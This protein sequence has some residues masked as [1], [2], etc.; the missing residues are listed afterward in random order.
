MGFRNFTIKPICNVSWIC[1]SCYIHMHPFIWH[2]ALNL[3]WL[4]PHFI[5]IS[6][7]IRW[8]DLPFSQVSVRV[9][10]VLIYLET[11]LGTFWYGN[12][13]GDYSSEYGTLLNARVGG[14]L[15]RRVAR[16]TWYLN[17]WA[18]AFFSFEKF[19]Q[20]EKLKKK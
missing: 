16:C 5:F 6:L 2:N 9:F 14:I 10:E 15:H 8:K 19:R 18:A 11:M 13:I 12:T 1:M 3:C 4:P 17:E 20:K 7:I